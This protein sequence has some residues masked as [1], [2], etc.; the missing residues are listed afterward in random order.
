M[1]TCEKV[2][3]IIDRMSETELRAEHERLERAV[4]RAS[5]AEFQRTLDDIREFREEVSRQVYGNF[6]KPQRALLP[7]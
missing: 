4:R 1:T 6:G 2:I 7:C 5:D 3:A